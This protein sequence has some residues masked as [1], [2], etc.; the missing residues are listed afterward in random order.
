MQVK[1]P[2]S[3]CR[4]AAPREGDAAQ[5]ASLAVL[6]ERVSA[7][8]KP[9]DVSEMSNHVGAAVGVILP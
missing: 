4:G 8:M 5:L 3:T 2:V 7:A 9:I 1:Q 6:L